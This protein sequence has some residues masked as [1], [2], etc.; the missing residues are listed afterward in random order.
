LKRIGEAFGNFT[1]DDLTFFGQCR[2]DHSADNVSAELIPRFRGVYRRRCSLSHSAFL[3]GIL[4]H[5]FDFEASRLFVEFAAMTR[6]DGFDARQMVRWRTISL[7][8]NTTT[9]YDACG[10]NRAVHD[11]E[12][13]FRAIAEGL[14]GFFATA[15]FARG[16]FPAIGIS[17]SFWAHRDTSVR[18]RIWSRPGA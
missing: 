4:A 7:G 2:G 12:V 6:V 5:A 15:S 17:I 14:P 1:A 3:R 16:F 13:K 8:G 9:V 18:A 11:D 10:R